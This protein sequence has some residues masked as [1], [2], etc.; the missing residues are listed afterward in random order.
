MAASR[1]LRR[2]ARWAVK[3]VGGL[4]ANL[5][6]L[7]VWVDGLGL[8]A[9]WAIGINWLLISAAGYVVADRWVFRATPSPTGLVAH[10]RQ[11]LGM[12]SVMAASKL[13]NYLLYLALLPVVDYRL[14][15]AVG[16]AVTFAGTFLG[17][18]LLWDRPQAISR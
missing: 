7:T 4:A 3:S 18:R 15:W 14:A 1:D 13:A 12:Q 5:A 11:W 8:A 6:L 10:A 2:A 9:W 16:A 17:T